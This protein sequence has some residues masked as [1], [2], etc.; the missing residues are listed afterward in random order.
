MPDLDLHVTVIET[1]QKEIWQ[2]K[3]ACTRLH[4]NCQHLLALT[5]VSSDAHGP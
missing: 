3:G 4:S 1:S 2:K 5:A